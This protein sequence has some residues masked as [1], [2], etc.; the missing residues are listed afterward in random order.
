MDILSLELENKN[1]KQELKLIKEHNI[2]LANELEDYKSSE[3][4]LK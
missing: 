4:H 3:A 1:L 2:L